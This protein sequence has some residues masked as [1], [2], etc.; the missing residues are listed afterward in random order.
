MW[1]LLRLVL[2]NLK[3]KVR[4]KAIKCVVYRKATNQQLVKSSKRSRRRTV[5]QTIQKFLSAA[6]SFSQVKNI[7]IRSSKWS[8]RKEL[9]QTIYKVLSAAIS[10]RQVK[11]KKM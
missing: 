8:Q 5:N 6:V 9:P 2:S 10:F 7:K 4:F 11:N 3:L 1:T